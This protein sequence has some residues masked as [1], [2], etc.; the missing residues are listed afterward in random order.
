[1]VYR[2]TAGSVDFFPRLGTRVAITSVDSDETPALLS[3][4]QI[5]AVGGLDIIVGGVDWDFRAGADFGWVL[6]Y[7]E[8]PETT[9]SSGQGPTAAG[10]AGGTYWLTE[11]FGL[12]VDLDFTADFLGFDGAASRFLP[13]SEQGRLVDAQLTVLD[14]RATAG[15]RLRL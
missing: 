13:E 14:F 8:R 12:G 7:S 11:Q 6:Q 10:R 9:G 3:S 5:A 15:I 2:L 1:M 4:T